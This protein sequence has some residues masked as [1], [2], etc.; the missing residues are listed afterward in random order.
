M[1]YI[2]RGLSDQA[3][4]PHLIQAV[5]YALICLSVAFGRREL[6]KMYRL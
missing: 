5:V 3:Q 6:V 2:S 1:S 4:T